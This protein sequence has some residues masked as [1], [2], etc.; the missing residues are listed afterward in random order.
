MS[1]HC[2]KPL[3]AVDAALSR[4]VDAGAQGVEPALHAREQDLFL[5]RDVVV[6]RG[7]GDAQARGDVVERRALEAARREQ[8]GRRAH[9]RVALGVALRAAFAGGAPGRFGRLSRH[10]TALPHRDLPMGWARAVLLEAALAT[11]R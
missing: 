1:Q 5:V 8:L 10:G 6:Q 3:A 4:L 7:L 2:T 9:D 11:L